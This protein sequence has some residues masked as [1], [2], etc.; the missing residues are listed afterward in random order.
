MST[1]RTTRSGFRRAKIDM[2]GVIPWPHSD[3]AARVM[4]AAHVAYHRRIDLRDRPRVS[5]SEFSIGAR[6]EREAFVAVGRD[7]VAALAVAADAG[8]VEV[9][10]ERAW[11]AGDIRPHVPRVGLRHQGHVDYRQDM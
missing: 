3:C 9:R 6:V 11:L 2:G 8:R 5:N 4:F 7:L 10:Q 1:A